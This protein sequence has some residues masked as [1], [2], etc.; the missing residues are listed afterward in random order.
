ME[1]N[2]SKKKK[3]TAIAIILIRILIIC[4]LLCGCNKTPTSNGADTKEDTAVSGDQNIEIGSQEDIEP[5]KTPSV[6]TI[7]VDIEN[8]PKEIKENDLENGLISLH[9]LEEIAK[10]ENKTVEVNSVTGATYIAKPNMVLRKDEEKGEPTNKEETK[11]E[12][13][14]PQNPTTVAVI[15]ENPQPKETQSAQ[16]NETKPT[17]TTIPTQQTTHEH[18]WVPVTEKKWV[19][20]KVAWDETVLV[21]AAWDEETPVAVQKEYSVAVCKCGAEFPTVQDFSSHSIMCLDTEEDEKHSSYH[22]DVRYETLYD[23]S[24]IHHDAE[25]ETI[26]HEEEGHYEDVTVGYKCSC[27]E[28]K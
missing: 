28:T 11:A 3:N 6:K 21:K 16:T 9:K 5:L 12:D 26:H 7:E 25:Y 14:K 19:V 23:T 20:D 10:V 27:G 2:K 1:K 22:V 8:L 17:E 24:V 18:S 13:D 4:L 15:T